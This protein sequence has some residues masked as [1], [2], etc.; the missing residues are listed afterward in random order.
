MPSR[1]QPT[2][3]TRNRISARG[4]ADGRCGGISTKARTA[5]SVGDCQRFE[6]TGRGR[7]SSIALRVSA[8]SP[9]SEVMGTP[10]LDARAR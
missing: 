10:R 2:F 1:A 8:K 3:H 5:S 6:K 7:D 4:R 9:Q